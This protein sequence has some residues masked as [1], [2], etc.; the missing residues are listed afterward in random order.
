MAFPDPVEAVAK[1]LTGRHGGHFM[2]WNI[3]EETYDYSL[4]ENQVL[5]FKFP[6]HPA[7]PLGLLI[8]VVGAV[9]PT[10]AEAHLLTT[11]MQRLLPRRCARASRTG[12][13]RTR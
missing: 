11:T 10:E 7:P 4:F 9:D 8:K 12:C 1:A 2:I 5:E 13:R 3:S 6:G